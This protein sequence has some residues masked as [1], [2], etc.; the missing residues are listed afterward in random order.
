M[1]L[2]VAQRVYGLAQLAAGKTAAAETYFQMSIK[3]VGELDPFQTALTQQALGQLLINLAGRSDEGA[4]L[5][6]AAAEA[7]DALV[8]APD[9]GRARESL[10]L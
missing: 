10:V 5:I 3:T 7:F 2:G 1:N 8:A 4:A 9:P 6:G